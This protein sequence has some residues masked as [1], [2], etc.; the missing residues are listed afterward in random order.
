MYCFMRLTRATIV[1][2]LL[3][4]A[5]GVGMGGVRVGSGELE[6]A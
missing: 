5:W 3:Y 4:A 1:G 2:L 6:T